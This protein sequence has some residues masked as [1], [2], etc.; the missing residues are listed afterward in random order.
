MP[1]Y[2]IMTC[3]HACLWIVKVLASY[4]AI[5]YLAKIAKQSLGRFN[6]I[7]GLLGILIRLWGFI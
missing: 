3:V 1:Q 2:C 4:I 7:H 6:S 5:V